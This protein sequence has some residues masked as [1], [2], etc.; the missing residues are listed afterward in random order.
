MKKFILKYKFIILAVI[1]GAALIYFVKVNYGQ[2]IEQ[3]YNPETIKNWMLSFGSLSFLVFIFLQIIQVVLFFIPGEVVQGA[4]GYIYGTILG[5][6]IS[7]TG[8]TIGA[9]ITFLVARKFGDSLL[10]KI[11]PRKDYE[12]A[13]TLIDKPKNRLMLF[14][15]YL[16]PGFPKDVLGYVAGIT[17][18]KLRWFI[19]FSTIARIPGIVMSAYVGSSLYEKNYLVVLIVVVIMVGLLIAGYLKGDKILEKLKIKQ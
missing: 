16:I 17:P 10:L 2:Y 13:K 19:L 8:I 11:L 5:S 9:I 4:G 18:I 6:V 15:L 7:L 3:Y 12:K 14:I 1:I